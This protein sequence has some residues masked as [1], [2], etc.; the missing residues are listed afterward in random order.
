MNN[1]NQLLSRCKF[2]V[3]VEI[4]AHRDYY[5]SVDEAIK[6][7][8]ANEIITPDDLSEEIKQ[9]MIE[10]DTMIYLQ[11]Y[12]DT[13]NGFFKIRHYDFDLAIEAAL[14]LLTDNNHD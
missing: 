13:P 4:N 6:E 10:L 3:Y 1:L 14:K 2:G 7:K 12:P 8:I 11:F 9:K 5:Q